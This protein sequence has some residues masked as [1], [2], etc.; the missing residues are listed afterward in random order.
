MM[1][2]NAICGQCS[3]KLGRYDDVI[4]CSGKCR[5]TYHL[6]CVGMS[7][8]SFRK[9]MDSKLSK[10][11]KCHFCLEEPEKTTSNAEVCTDRN[12]IVA[13]EPS[14][15]QLTR[16]ERRALHDF[17]K[18]RLELTIM[19]MN[20]HLQALPEI[21]RNLKALGAQVTG[22]TAKVDEMEKKMEE[23]V[24]VGRKLK[25]NYRFKPFF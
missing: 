10:T 8:E 18:D 9:V 24:E 11:W 12:R 4:D 25:E 23:M 20:Q 16:E 1:P 7:Y 13:E 22:M 6:K 21:A 2:K 3:V 19:S 14:N 15:S 17:Q 5:Q